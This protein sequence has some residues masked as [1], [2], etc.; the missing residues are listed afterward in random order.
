MPIGTI[1]PHGENLRRWTEEAI[2]Q[3]RES[4]E[5]HGFID[6][7]IANAA[8]GCEGVI[9]GGHFRHKIAKELGIKEVPVVC[10]SIADRDQERDILIRM[11]KAIGEFDLDLLANFDEAFLRDV[12]FTSEEMDDIFGIDEMPGQFDLAKELKKLDI[13]KISI[14]KCDV[15]QLGP[16]RLA[17]GDSTVENCWQ[18]LEVN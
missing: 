15:I 18:T 16:H 3:L 10:L 9:L 4:I 11:N 1:R 8:P 14:K 13:K 7:I 12:G 2:S 5:R 6:P 17:C